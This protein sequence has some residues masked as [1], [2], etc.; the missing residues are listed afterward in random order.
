MTATQIR[1]S[2]NSMKEAICKV[3]SGGMIPVDNGMYLR[4]VMSDLDKIVDE[5]EKAR[6]WR[7][8]RPA[9]SQKRRAIA[10]DAM[11]T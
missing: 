10:I 1:N 2:A 7:Q 6:V 9:Q 8:T 3:I 11:G 4:A 5:V